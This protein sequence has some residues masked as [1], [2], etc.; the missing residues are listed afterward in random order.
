MALVQPRGSAEADE[1]S[2]RPERQSVVVREVGLRDGLQLLSSWPSTEQKRQWL[3]A[4]QEAGVREMEVGSFVPATAMPQFGDVTEVAHFARQLPDVTVTALIPNRRGAERAIAA[5]VH[6]LN[7]VVSVSERHNLANVRRTPQES[8]AQ[9]RDV[10]EM[11]AGLPPSERPQIDVGLSTAFGCTMEGRIAP[12]AVIALAEQVAHAGVRAITI[13]DT[14]GYADPKAVAVLSS[15]LLRRF[16]AIALGIHLH[17]TRGLGLA[18]AHA[19]F[20][21]GVRTFDASLGGLG[22]CP[23][24]P[25]ATGNVATEDLVYLFEMMGIA[26]GIDLKRLLAL[27][28]AIASMVPADALEGKLIRAGLPKNYPGDVAAGEWP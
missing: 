28:S 17:D 13:A 7:F 1:L 14:V 16:P 10:I 26:T 4:E 19:A 8:V 21:V 12:E 15:E 23:H 11:V 9:L 25:G 18:N 27:R 5:G 2:G 3:A 24:A 22:G 20:D 6:K